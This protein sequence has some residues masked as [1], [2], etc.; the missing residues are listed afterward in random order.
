MTKSEMD[1]E[2]SGKLAEARF[3]RWINSVGTVTLPLLAGF[4]IT[5]VVVVSDDAPN[6]LWPG[7]TILVLVFAALVLI[8]AVL[9]VYHARIY[10][11]KKDPDHEKFLYWAK[12]ARCVYGTGLFALLIGL[13][14][15]VAPRHFAGIQDYFRVVAVILVGL[16]CLGHFLWAR[17]D[18][19]LRTP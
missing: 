12:L 17:L 11:P 14:L 5:S 1:P 6:F 2:T 9:C 7:A 4:S 10:L 15:V 13:A 8:A 16:A 3:K 18:G 19:W